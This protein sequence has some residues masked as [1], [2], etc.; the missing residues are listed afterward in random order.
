MIRLYKD[1]SILDSRSG[2]SSLV[3]CPSPLCTLQPRRPEKHH[4]RRWTLYILG[5]E[6]I[7]AASF[8][9]FD[10]LYLGLPAALTLLPI[11]L[12]FASDRHQLFLSLQYPTAH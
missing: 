5:S 10:L 4:F 3:F 7:Y 9:L 1:P 12:S 2:A 11:R 8:Y 6:P